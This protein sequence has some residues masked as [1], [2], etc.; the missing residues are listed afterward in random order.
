MHWEIEFPEVFG[1]ENPGFDVMVGNPPFLGGHRIWPVLGG[2]YR[3]YLKLQHPETSGKA[4]DLV[5]HFFRRCFTLLRRRG[6]SGL[7]ATNT[8][9]Q[10]D[11]R[12]AGL[13]YLC[14]TGG[15]IYSARRRLRWPGTAAVVVSVV[16]V[17]KGSR[18]PATLDGKVVLG[19]NSFLFP[20]QS[21]FDPR[22]LQFNSRLSYRGSMVYGMGFTFDDV[23]D[24][25]TPL[26]RMKELNAKDPRNQECIYRFV[27]GENI[28]SSPT[29]T[30]N[31]F[32]INFRQMS[33]QRAGE[34]PDLLEIVRQRVKPERDHLGGY[35]VANRRRK[36][37]WQYGSY[38]AALHTA[39]S[40]MPRCLALS[41]VSQYLS[42][43]FQ[44]TDRV[45]SHTAIV[46][47]CLEFSAFCALQSSPHEVWVRFFGSSL[48]DRLR[49]TP[50]DCFDTFPF[51]TTG[52]PTPPSRPPA[53][54]TTS[55]GPT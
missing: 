43:C 45:Y 14:R 16:H 51:Q 18:S 26:D 33:L 30:S 25:A 22:S 29:Q 40:T 5:A 4:V 38:A 6:T 9:A 55:S 8:I 3:D 23:S 2:P 15:T 52:R 47:P 7:I 19:L 10:G 54:P 36:Y 11:T 49:Y 46:F 48:E 28:N 31:R 53:A 20:S 35:A 39:L 27:G 41:Q 50:S 21:D 12:S 1:R 13:R 24:K 37:W 44:P 42:L 17:L 34:W 32:I